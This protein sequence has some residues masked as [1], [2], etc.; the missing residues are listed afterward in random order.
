MAFVCR[1]LH[2]CIA[3]LVTFVRLFASMCFDINPQIA[4]K[5]WCI[6]TLATFVSLFSTVCCKMRP[7][8]TCIKRCIVT[9]VTHVWFFPTVFFQIG[10]SPLCILNEP[11][12]DHYQWIHIYTGCICV[13]LHCVFFQMFA[14]CT[15]ISGCKDTLGTFV[16]FFT[17]VCSQMCLQMACYWGCICTLVAILCFFLNSCLS[18][19]NFRIKIQHF[20]ICFPFYHQ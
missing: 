3:A 16:R 8:S 6:I 4:L 17:S 5:R 13:A 14:Q 11:S 20:Q 19:G 2:S 15:W 18:H 10:L 1:K 9:L 12:N 7:Q